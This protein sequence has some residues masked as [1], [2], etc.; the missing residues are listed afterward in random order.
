MY[1]KFDLKS[2]L[3]KIENKDVH[4]LLE[5]WD[6]ANFEYIGKTLQ[7]SHPDINIII[8]Q[9]ILDNGDIDVKIYK[10]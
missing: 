9:I 7:V 6:K 10:K 5:G 4:L 3:S 8:K 1:Y 2:T